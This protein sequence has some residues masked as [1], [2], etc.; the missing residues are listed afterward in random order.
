MNSREFRI[1]SD[2]L[3]ELF[4]RLRQKTGF[5]IGATD[6][7]AELW[8]FSEAFY[9]PLVKL[10]RLGHVSLFEKAKTKSV[11][12]IVIA[13]RKFQGSFEFF[14]CL[15]KLAHH[16]VGLTEQ[17]MSDCVSRVPGNSSLQRVDRFR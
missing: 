1:K 4:N 12:S 5:A 7:Y 2:C 17:V 6:Q 11:L 13:R 15:F 14:G 9:H 3:F 10:F 8:S 16:E